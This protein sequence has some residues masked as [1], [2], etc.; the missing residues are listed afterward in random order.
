MR[1]FI[2]RKRLTSQ[3]ARAE[4][5]AEVVFH[6]NSFRRNELLCPQLDLGPNRTPTATNFASAVSGRRR[7]SALEH[8]R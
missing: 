3:G 7:A 1:C 8:D 2:A 6:P 5:F 4:M